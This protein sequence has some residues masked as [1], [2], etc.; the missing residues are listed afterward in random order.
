M[1]DDAKRKSLWGKLARPFRRKRD[2]DRDH[3]D[4]M[5]RAGQGETDKDAAFEKMMTTT[6]RSGQGGL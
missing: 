5:R 1:G 6:Y 2:R 4:D 3:G